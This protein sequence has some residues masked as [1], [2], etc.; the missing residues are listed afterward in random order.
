MDGP[1][2]RSTPNPLQ[3]AALDLG[4]LVVFFVVFS[5]WDIYAA[6]AVFMGTS[7]LALAITW[8]RERRLHPVPLV[9]AAIVLVFGGLT[10]WLQN[11]TFVKV[12]VTIIYGLLGTALLIGHLLKKPLIKHV[13]GEGLRL[14]EEGWRALTLAG[15]G[16]FYALGGLNEIV[17]RNTSTETW[18][19]FKTFAL[20]V[21]SILF[22][23]FLTPI[24]RRYDQGAD[25]G[26]GTH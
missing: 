7:V 19:S 26:G 2:P 5:Y 24:L 11:D 21:L 4:P 3:R 12:K 9:T 16:Y 1:N 17:W 6:T 18:V 23:L 8:F 20:P 13:F 14:A 22:F 25:G 10:L 15:I